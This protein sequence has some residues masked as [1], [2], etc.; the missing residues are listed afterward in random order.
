MTDQVPVRHRGPATRA[1]R[2]AGWLMLAYF[3][4]ILGDLAWHLRADLTTGDRVVESY[5]WV[6]GMQA[7]L[8]WPVDLLARALLLQ[9]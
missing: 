9:L 2:L 7:S 3:C 1:A 5:E 6:I 4:G 8:F